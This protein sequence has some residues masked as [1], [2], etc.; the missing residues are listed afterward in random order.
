MKNNKHDNQTR[1]NASERPVAIS[2]KLKKQ[3]R[4]LFAIIATS[5]FT[6]SMAMFIFFT[7]VACKNKQEIIFSQLTTCFE[8]YIG[9][10]VRNTSNLEPEKQLAIIN[11]NFNFGY[12]N[13]WLRRFSQFNDR[14]AV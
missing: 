13:N 6:L 11:H 3:K 2:N 7:V 1:K 10:T 8:G 14:W 9:S 5:L 12:I 4:R